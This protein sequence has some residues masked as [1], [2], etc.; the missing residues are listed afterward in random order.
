ME[1]IFNQIIEFHYTK[2]NSKVENYG[3]LVYDFFNFNFFRMH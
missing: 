2:V 3:F 1:S